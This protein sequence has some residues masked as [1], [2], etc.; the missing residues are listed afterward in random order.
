MPESNTLLDGA[1]RMRHRL[2][3]AFASGATFV[4]APVA[5]PGAAQGPGADSSTTLVAA[6]AWVPTRNVA[7]APL[8]RTISLDLKE[9]TIKQVLREIGRRG[10]IEI[11]YGDDVLRARTHVSLEAEQITVQDGVVT[12]L[13][14]TGLEAFVSLSGT[15]IL[16]RAGSA[17]APRDSLM[18]RVTDTTGAA[19]AGGRTSVDPPRSAA[20]TGAH[21][22]D[23]L[24]E[25]P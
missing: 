6:A 23:S 10:G 3:T 22:H 11:A 19:R 12:A 13:A 24:A 25:G 9:A 21:G 18:G 1:T 16:V 7:V 20:V 4:F 8:R 17:A 14:G 2:L 15:T 5:A